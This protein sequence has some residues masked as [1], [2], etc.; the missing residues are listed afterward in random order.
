LRKQAKQQAFV[1][2]WK[3][4]G[5]SVPEFQVSFLS[6]SFAAFLFHHAIASYFISWGIGGAFSFNMEGLTVYMLGLPL[7]SALIAKRELWG[8]Y[9]LSR[10]S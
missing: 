3:A 1:E 5:A 2:G 6:P 4:E 8:L 9:G 7:D 10:L